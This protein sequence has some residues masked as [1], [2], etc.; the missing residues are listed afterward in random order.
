MILAGDLDAA[1]AARL[2]GQ[3][4]DDERVARIDGVVARAQERLRRELEHVV[5]AVAEH[6]PFRT[7]A[8]ALRERRS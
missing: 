4:I 2:R 1:R 3:R 5:A 8:Q 7:D 6:D